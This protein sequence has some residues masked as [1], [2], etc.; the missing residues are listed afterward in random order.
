MGCGGRRNCSQNMRKIG[1]TGFVRDGFGQTWECPEGA[2]K[3][4]SREAIVK[5]GASQCPV[6]PTESVPW[7]SP[8]VLCYSP[9]IGDLQRKRGRQKGVSLVCSRNKSEQIGAYRSK[10]E[11]IPQIRSANPNKSEENGE[12]G[13][14]RGEP[15]LASL[16]SKNSGK[17]CP[18][19]QCLSRPPPAHPLPMPWST[20]PSLGKFCTGSVQTGSECNSPFCSKFCCCLPLSFKR[21]REKRETKK[22]R[23]KAKKKK[24][25]NA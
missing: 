6:R 19:K 10:S 5:S 12:I 2:E 8:V 7:T 24:R 17:R 9:W 1:M 20:P 23:R 18:Q 11:Q 13:K 14:D 15:L 25:Q 21:R 4:S 16:D 22:K 3:A